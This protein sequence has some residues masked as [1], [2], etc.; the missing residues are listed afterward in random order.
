MC[1][2]F[3]YFKKVYQIEFII[4]DSLDTRSSHVTCERLVPNPVV[5]NTSNCSV[6]WQVSRVSVYPYT[7]FVCTGW[8]VHYP[9]LDVFSISTRC[10][11]RNC[12]RELFSVA[13]VAGSCT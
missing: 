8:H 7:I 11:H 6:T 12:L 2:V 5:L 13:F 4:N 10:C 3:A 1:Y 9:N